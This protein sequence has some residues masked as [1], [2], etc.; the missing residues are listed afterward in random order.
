MLSKLLESRW[1][2]RC[3][4]AIHKVFIFDVTALFYS[5]LSFILILL[6]FYG[7]MYIV[8][9]LEYPE[10]YFIGPGSF[11]DVVYLL[12]KNDNVIAPLLVTTLFLVIPLLLSLGSII[13]FKSRGRYFVIAVFAMSTIFISLYTF[14]INKRD[15]RFYPV[16]YFNMTSLV[17]FFILA[18]MLLYAGYLSYQNHK[19][20]KG[21]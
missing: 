16:N 17:M 18:I 1:F 4:L 6:Y 9:R 21:E 5:G 7:Q 8:N 2:K 13:R 15:Y 12:G 11:Y 14:V 3:Y 10:S 19:E 20:T